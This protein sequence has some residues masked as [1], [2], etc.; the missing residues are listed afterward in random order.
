MREL[1]PIL[2]VQIRSL[3]GPIDADM[4]SECDESFFNLTAACFPISKA[5]KQSAFRAKL[6]R[7]DELVLTWLLAKE[8][9]SLRVPSNMKIPEP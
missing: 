6:I 7:L 8:S 5:K 1:Q 4:T 2:R 9:G 3:S